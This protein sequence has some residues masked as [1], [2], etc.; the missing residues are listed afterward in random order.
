[1]FNAVVATIV[2]PVSAGHI[3]G[4][5]T[6]CAVI[7]KHVYVHVC[8]DHD[9]CVHDLRFPSASLCFYILTIVDIWPLIA[10]HTYRHTRTCTYQKRC[11]PLFCCAGMPARTIGA[12]YSLVNFCG[13]V[14]DAVNWS[15]VGVLVGSAGKNVCM[16]RLS[17]KVKRQLDDAQ[18][19][20]LMS[21]VVIDTTPRKNWLIII[22]DFLAKI[23][24]WDISW[25]QGKSVWQLQTAF[26][27]T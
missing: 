14:W 27:D 22:R 3:P 15:V 5:C 20:Q 17:D 24:K 4:S 19:V 26:Y 10:N 6:Y 18:Y 8:H 12:M 23:F 9:R 2:M 11:N 21:S 7:T 13:F 1:M 16:V 25:S